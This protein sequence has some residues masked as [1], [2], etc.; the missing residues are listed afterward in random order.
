MAADD[1]EI[2]SQ[3]CLWDNSL[4]PQ[5]SDSGCNW[6]EEWKLDGDVEQGGYFINKQER[7]EVFPAMWGFEKQHLLS[8]VVDETDLEEGAMD[9]L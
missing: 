7:G 4:A 8:T 2:N 5:L 9:W 3:E 6:L 1:L